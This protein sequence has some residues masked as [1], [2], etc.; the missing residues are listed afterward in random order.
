MAADIH[1]RAHARNPE[2][3]ETI[4]LNVILRPDERINELL[5]S[6]SQAIR[7]QF[8]AEFVLG[9]KQLSHM[10]AFQTA[11]PASQRDEVET[12]VK[13][14]ASQWAAHRGP[15]EIVMG[16]VAPL[17]AKPGSQWSTLLFW[18]ARRN[19]LM[20]EF[21]QRLLQLLTPLRSPEMLAVHAELR[22]DPHVPQ[23]LIYSLNL[24][25][26][27]LAGEAERPHFT[28]TRLTDA[29]D[30]EPALTLARDMLAEWQGHEL[31][32]DKVYL[33]NAGA[34]GTVT[35]IFTEYSLKE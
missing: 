15:L 5:I 32:F 34:H 16:E 11:Y 23:S 8:G 29:N 31:T 27:P 19:K 30:V 35:E 26:T 10:S 24:Y 20:T 4:G 21:H 7:Q 2:R 22:A 3:G 1:R 25:G 33:A 28:F 9:T 12:R 17:I 6:V 18:D 13:Q 14:F